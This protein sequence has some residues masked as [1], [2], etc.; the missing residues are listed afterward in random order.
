MKYQAA[1]SKKIWGLQYVLN[2]FYDKYLH[3]FSMRIYDIQDINISLYQWSSDTTANAFI[4]KI[5]QD[6]MEKNFIFYF[7]RY[8]D[9][10]SW[11]IMLIW[12]IW[13]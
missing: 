2:N 11:N 3:V 4:N 13:A 10:K 8:I 12:W 5:T 9:F 1:N 6:S 7:G